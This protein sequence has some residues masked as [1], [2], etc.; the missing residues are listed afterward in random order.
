MD[1]DSLTRMSLKQL[2]QMC[3]D[4]GEPLSGNK[5]SLVA[6][7]LRPALPLVLQSRRKNKLYVPERGSVNSAILVELERRT[8]T[9]KTQA[10]W[11]KE[12]ILGM[13]STSEFTTTNVYE[14]KGG[15]LSWGSYDGWS[16]A[17]RLRQA[18]PGDSQPMLA[19]VRGK[20]VRYGLTPLGR[21]I[22][23]AIHKRAHDLGGCRCAYQFPSYHSI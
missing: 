11:T 8:T 13:A 2:K 20:P 14:K 9:N 6:R 12:E 1:E 10:C 19:R 5:K 21:E 15:G 22:G 17:S 7:L 4:R 18:E 16:G 3:K 23:R